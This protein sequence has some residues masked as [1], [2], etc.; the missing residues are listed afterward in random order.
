[1]I[2]AS[3][4]RRGARDASFLPRRAP[5]SVAA[6]SGGSGTGKRIADTENGS[7]RLEAF[8]RGLRVTRIEPMGFIVV[9]VLLVL[10][11]MSGEYVA[12]GT[13]LRWPLFVMGGLS[14]L[15]GVIRLSERQDAST[16]S[17]PA[18]SRPEETDDAKPVVSANVR[19]TICNEPLVIVHGASGPFM[20]HEETPA[21]YHPASPP[22]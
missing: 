6:C 18:E 11:G 3:L 12:R 22:D 8:K 13:D 4:C 10:A 17:R 15:A 9:G 7:H 1:V 19:C 14:V 2:G 16:P 21:P 20:S 5:E